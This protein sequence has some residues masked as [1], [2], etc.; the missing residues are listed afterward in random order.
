[1]ANKNVPPLP[2]REAP[3]P[4]VFPSFSQKQVLE[5]I[6][7]QCAPVIGR[8]YGK[9][10]HLVVLLPNVSEA[11]FA[12]LN[13]GQQTPANAYEQQYQ[14]MGHI[15]AKDGIITIVVTHF[16]YIYSA[17]RGPTHA[18]VISGGDTSMLDALARERKIY[19]QLEAK[20]NRT[21][22][23][24][25]LDPFLSVAG[26][27]EPVIFGHTHPSLHA[28]FSPTDYASNQATVST[29][30]AIMCV[31]PHNEEIACYV[32]RSQ[33]GAPARVL[34]LTADNSP[35]ETGTG[36]RENSKNAAESALPP[37][38]L[39]ELGKLC[40]ALLQDRRNR[41]KYKTYR[42]MNGKLH[43]KLKLERR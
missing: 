37:A 34:L 1:M 40:T 24:Y 4:R 21:P 6:R 7:Q 19:N 41:G 36:K 9:G 31:D 23:G 26:E 25:L 5:L 39:E 20:Y 17:S 43:V 32:G 30:S 42:G 15:L 11:L 28:W 33:H 16:L 29:P 18:A 27:S 2:K 3:P 22:D 35:K 12:A 13:Y 38:E 14:L 10:E 8:F